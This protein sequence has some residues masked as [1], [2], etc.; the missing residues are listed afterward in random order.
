[1]D[2]S[3][4]SFKNDL[5]FYV[6][7]YSEKYISSVSEGLFLCLAQKENPQ[8]IKFYKYLDLE[9]FLNY[10]PKKKKEKIEKKKEKKEGKGK[11]FKIN[12][13]IAAHNVIELDDG[14]LFLGEAYYPTYRS[15]PIPETI[16]INGRMQNVTR[17]R[18]VFDGY[19]YTH[20]LYTIKITETLHSRP[21]INIDA[22]SINCGKF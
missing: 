22:C 20:D 10:L 1:M 6:G 2:V 3:A 12:Y 4:S 7:T 16:M 9:N 18:T 14:Y 11:D 13:R 15:E 21:R 17:Y 8:F 19:Q 5:N